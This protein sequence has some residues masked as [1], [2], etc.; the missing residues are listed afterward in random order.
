MTEKIIPLG[1]TVKCVATGV[2]GYAMTVTETFNGNLR[3]GVQPKD[4]EGVKMPDAWEID[5]HTLDIIDEGISARGTPPPPS[6]IAVGERVKDALS[7][8]EGIVANKT[9]HLN[10]C[11]YC[12]V[13]PQVKKETL[14][15]EA[16]AGSHI[17]VER[18][19]KVDGGVTVKREKESTPERRSGG[20]STRSVRV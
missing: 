14:L 11:V 2:R 8:F 16:P 17:A 9:T 10:G 13:V 15:N 4:E 19:V 3:Y 5:H 18:L 20:P 1:T 6:D 7:G 12:L